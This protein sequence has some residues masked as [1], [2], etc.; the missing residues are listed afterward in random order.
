MNFVNLR[1][2]GKNSTQKQEK[3]LSV[4]VTEMHKT[5]GIII[6]NTDRHI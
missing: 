2:F 5:I 4:G 1:N 3:K 6:H